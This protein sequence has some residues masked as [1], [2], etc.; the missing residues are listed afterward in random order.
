VSRSAAVLAS[1][2]VTL[3]RP[4]WWVLA[5]STFL[6]RGGLLLFL[7]PIVSIPSPLALS[8]VLAPLIVPVAFGRIGADV[9]LLAAVSAI[10]IFI[11]LVVGGWLAAAIELALIREAAGA[12]I[13]EGVVDGPSPTNEL[14]P[15]QRD[16]AGGMLATR[17]VVGLPLAAAVGLGAVRI[18]AVTYSELTNPTDVAQSLPIR[19]A[20]GATTEIAVIVA[21]W[22]VAELVGGIAG[23]RVALA[24]AGVWRALGSA[25]VD[26]VRRPR[27]FVAPWL[28]WSIVLWGV[29]AGLLVAARV[30]W[31]QAQAA[32]SASRPDGIAI[33]AMLVVFV[34]V[35]LAGLSL[36]GLLAA[37]RTVGGTFED[38]R[39][40]AQR[41]PRTAGHADGGPDDPGTFGASTHH[42]PGDWSVGDDGGSL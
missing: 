27:S 4:T 29:L 3:G 24:G 11:W 23:R 18:V 28:L 39:A 15:R 37:I 26:A 30:T 32:M 40:S 35:W 33:A 20:L 38:L 8:N 13:D 12:A 42:R 19:V 17:L 22:L 36:A 41:D 1:L 7:L 2:L 21:A 5:L 14:P 10:A 6:V 16:V 25:V 34:A 9:L 31:D